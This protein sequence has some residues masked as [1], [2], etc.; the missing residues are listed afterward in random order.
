MLAKLKDAEKELERVRSAQM[1]AKVDDIVGSGSDIGRFR[2]WTFRGPDNMTG[3]DLRQMAIKA[4]NMARKDLPVA[5]LGA[6]VSGSKVS[7]IAT[8]NDVAIK[9][10]LTARQLLTIAAPAIEGRGGGKDDLA[11]GGGTNPSGLNDAFA[12]AKRF[13]R[14][15]DQR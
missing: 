5:M 11:Q 14:E 10:G 2:L 8:V 12:D 15:L 6:S 4:K 7:L 9:S 1:L 13:L 3:N